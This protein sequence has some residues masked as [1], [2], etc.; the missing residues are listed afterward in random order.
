MVR[1][2]FFLKCV[3][4]IIVLYLSSNL[5]HLGLQLNWDSHPQEHIERIEKS[6]PYDSLFDMMDSQHICNK[7]AEDYNILLCLIETWSIRSFVMGR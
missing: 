5:Q 2:E 1:R 3:Y 4:S 6:I 7:V